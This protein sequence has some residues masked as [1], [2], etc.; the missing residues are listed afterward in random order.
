MCLFHAEHGINSEK[1]FEYVHQQTAGSLDPGASSCGELQ[2]VVRYSRKWQQQAPVTV[3]D[4]LPIKLKPYFSHF[5]SYGCVQ[6]K[7][8]NPACRSRYGYE[9]SLVS[10]S[11][12][13]SRPARGFSFAFNIVVSVLSSPLS[14]DLL[15]LAW[16]ALNKLMR[17]LDSCS[18]KRQIRHFL[19]FRWSAVS[20]PLSS[21]AQL[22][23][24]IELQSRESWL[25]MKPSC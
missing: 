2:E 11:P 20:L 8:T 13:P 18:S 23:I 4:Y 17:D 9:Q 16:Q 19:T 6:I 22:T 24:C 21:A 5:H 1:H 12:A 3:T 7:Q 15:I 14:P 25:M 10:C